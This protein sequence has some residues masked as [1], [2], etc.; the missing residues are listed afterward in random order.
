MQAII[1]K[2]IKK[3]IGYNSVQGAVQCSVRSV[4][5]ILCKMHRRYNHRTEKRTKNLKIKKGKK[6]KNTICRNRVVKFGKSC[7]LRHISKRFQAEHTKSK[8]S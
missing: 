8:G 2:K 1:K 3:N 4:K 6:F 5:Q 7:G